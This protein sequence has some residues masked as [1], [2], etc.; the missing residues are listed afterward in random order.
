MDSGVKSVIAVHLEKNQEIRFT[1]C[2]HGLYY[3]YT[4]IFSPMKTPEDNITNNETIDEYKSSVNG[5]SFV[6]TVATHK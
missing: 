1:R 5:Y 4:A 2:V 6:S 3:F